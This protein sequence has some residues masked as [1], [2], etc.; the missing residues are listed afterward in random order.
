[1]NCPYEDTGKRI[2][3]LRKKYGLTREL[4]AEMSDISVQFLADIEKGRKNM[5]VTT[6][7]KICSSLHVTADYIINGSVSTT[8]EDELINLCRSLS[9]TRQEQAIKMLTVFVE[10]IENS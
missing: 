5:T 2:L 10:A 4:L 8:T 9:P 1:M 3:S 6:L 7:R